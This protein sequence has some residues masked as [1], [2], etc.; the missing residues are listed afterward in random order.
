LGETTTSID[1][2]V[3]LGY[4]CS[5]K[6]SVGESLARRLGWGFLDFDV[7]IEKREG[8]TVSEIIDQ[9]GEDAFREM[10]AALT[11][12][13][14]EQR[15][16]VLAPGG[17]WITQPDLL[18]GMRRGTFSAWLAVTPAETVRRLKEDT[19]DRP[20]RDHP[21]PVEAIREMLDERIALY[22]RADVKIP[23]DGRGIEQVAFEIE[24]LL[25]TRICA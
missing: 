9:R 7:E 16:L 13:A 24:Q 5:G 2:I 3:L 18:E 10:E 1:R 20:F 19:I 15:S 17:G 11:R 6:S 22:R 8:A 4:M 23:T 12:E 14:T 25:R 21:N